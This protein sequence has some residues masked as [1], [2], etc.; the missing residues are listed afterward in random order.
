MLKYK[1]KERN[2]IMKSYYIKQKA[3]SIGDKFKVYD[4]N[5]NVKYYVKSRLFSINH[6]KHIYNDKDELVITLRRRFFDILPSYLIYDKNDKLIAI[7]KRKFSISKKF[8]IEGPKDQYRIDGNLFAYNFSIYQNDELIG[9]VSKKFI[10]L[11][12]SYRL[13]IFKDEDEEFFIA[14]VIAFD[15]LYHNGGDNT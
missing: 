6:V 5:N 10:Q 13:E 9:T 15:N 4:D 3:F 11:V 2:C 8:A 7:F 12:D 1:Y 14:L